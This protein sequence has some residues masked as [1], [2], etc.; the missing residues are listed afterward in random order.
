MILGPLSGVAALGQT[1]SAPVVTQ[2]ATS[3]PA[4]RAAVDP[5]VDRILMHLEARD[6]HDLRAGVAWRQQYVLDTEE[7][8]VT[9]RGEIWYQ[10]A[11]PVAKFLIHFTEKIADARKDKLDEQHLFDGCWYIEIQSRT[12]SVQRREVRRATDPGNPYKVGE[13]VFPLPFGQKK[14]DILREFDVSLVAPAAGDPADTDHLRLVPHAGTREGES[15]KELDFWVSRA[16]PLEGLPIKVRVAKLDG[17]GK[18]NSH[19]TITFDNVHLD[20]GFNPNIF[21]YKKPEGYTEEPPEYLK[22]A[23]APRDAAGGKE[24]KQP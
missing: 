6:V 7:A 18:L 22:P 14:E 4:T 15:Y 10:K 3:A 23:D 2:P 1:T 12:K 8:A 24:G 5:Q 9:K 13:G 20:E 16:G 19:I 11:E 21:E 17:T